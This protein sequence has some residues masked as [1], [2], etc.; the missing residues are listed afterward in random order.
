MIDNT[1][2]EAAWQALLA[3]A[4]TAARLRKF[5]EAEMLGLQ[6]IEQAEIVFG[7]NDLKVAT[8][9]MSLAMI[10]QEQREYENAEALY[11]RIREILAIV[12]ED[13]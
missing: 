6:A 9:L 1:G 12:P 2:D 5:E 8:S 4:E 11:M 10:Y 7:A 13:T 3:R